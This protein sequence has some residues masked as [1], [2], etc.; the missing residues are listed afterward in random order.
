MRVC[1]CSM[2]LGVKWSKTSLWP[3]DW[4]AWVDRQHVSP[5]RWSQGFLLDLRYR[6]VDQSK[7]MV[8]W[9][10]HGLLYLLMRHFVKFIIDLIYLIEQSWI[11][12]KY[13]LTYSICKMATPEWSECFG[14]VW[15][16]PTEILTMGQKH[17]GH[18]CTQRPVVGVPQC[19]VINHVVILKKNIRENI[20]T[21]P[22]N[23]LDFLKMSAYFFS[24]GTPHPLFRSI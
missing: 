16:F 2:F 19:C 3:W 18:A 22:M 10:I 12:T 15:G 17:P 8:E 9:Y 11:V 6:S 1:V 20:G 4:K 7:C 23:F 14:D 21:H 24:I 13:T 5:E